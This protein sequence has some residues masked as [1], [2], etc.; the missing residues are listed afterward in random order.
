MAK[1]KKS[2]KKHAK[3]SSKKKQKKHGRL[4]SDKTK[5]SKIRKLIKLAKSGFLKK[6]KNKKLKEKRR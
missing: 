6:V 4:P 2:S 1:K 3:P 5:L